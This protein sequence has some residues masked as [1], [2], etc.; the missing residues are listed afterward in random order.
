MIVEWSSMTPMLLFD[1]AKFLGSRLRAFW[2]VMVP[3]WIFR[4]LSIMTIKSIRKDE[5]RV[6]H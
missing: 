1:M 5:A 6:I 3:C 4:M 2:G